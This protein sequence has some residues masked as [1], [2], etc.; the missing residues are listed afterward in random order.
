MF[1]TE[2]LFGIPVYKIKID[3]GLYDKE[4]ILSTI[5]KN[6]SIGPR[7]KHNYYNSTMHMSL[8]DEGKD[9]KFENMNYDKLSKV[10]DNVFNNFVKKLKL[11]YKGKI[12]LAYEIAQYTVLKKDD[13]MGYHNHLPDSDFACVHYLQ[14]N[15]DVGTKIKNTH[16]FSDYYRYMRPDMYKNMDKQDTINSYAFNDFTLSVE[17]D[18]MVIFPTVADHGIKKIDTVSDKLRITIATNLT[19]NFS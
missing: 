13:W 5:K 15:K 6:Y 19:L 2:I 11:N 10:Y 4:K 8:Y 16:S 3:P 9:P 18:D 17:E 7:N 14:L 12:N 1:Q